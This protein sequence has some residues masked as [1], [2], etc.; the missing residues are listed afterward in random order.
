M[1][2]AHTVFLIVLQQRAEPGRL[3]LHQLCLMRLEQL[4]VDHLHHATSGRSSVPYLLRTTGHGKSSLAHL[5]QLLFGAAVQVVCHS[6]LFKVQAVLRLMCKR[7]LS[8]L[9]PNNDTR[10]AP[11]AG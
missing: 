4:L 10:Q 1:T 5:E 2:M 11:I 9:S 6:L 8:V 3:F 7:L